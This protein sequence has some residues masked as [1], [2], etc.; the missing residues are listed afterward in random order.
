MI[1]DE[2]DQ[3]GLDKTG[4]KTKPELYLRCVVEH[5]ECEREEAARILLER[6]WTRYR[7]GEEVERLCL[8][9]ILAKVESLRENVQELLKAMDSKGH[10][11]YD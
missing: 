10:N 7:Q 11:L 1:F 5:E 3:T 4:L 8:E 2:Q 6:M 9:T